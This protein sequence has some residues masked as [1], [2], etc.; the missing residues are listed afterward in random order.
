[1]KKQMCILIV[2]L[3]I[4][5]TVIPVAAT[6]LTTNVIS[7]STTA[8]SRISETVAPA[9]KASRTLNPELKAIRADLQNFRSTIQ[10]NRLHNETLRLENQV[11]RLKL[12]QLLADVKGTLPAASREQLKKSH[13]DIKAI[14]LQLADTKGDIC[15]IL[16][17]LRGLIE[18]KNWQGV[19][20]AYNSIVAIQKARADK[21]T[22]INV[23]LKQMIKI[24][25]P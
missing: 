20:D 13:Q 15:D 6:G 23:I 17:T 16:A 11:L 22:Q 12:R 10:Q 8:A 3:L 25:Q 21:L 9:V 5:L 19:K 24:V 18:K 1:M 7:S 4:A 14:I 2:A